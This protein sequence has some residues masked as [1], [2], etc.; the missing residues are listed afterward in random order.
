MGCPIKVA[1]TL[2]EPPAKKVEVIPLTE[3]KD[4][5]IIKIAEEIFGN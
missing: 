5:D 1:C 4:N 3:T 2:T